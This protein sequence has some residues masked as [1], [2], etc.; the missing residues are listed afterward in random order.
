LLSGM[1][2]TILVDVDPRDPATFLGVTVILAVI[3]LLGLY[4]PARRASRV[5]PV[6]ALAAE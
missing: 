2:G 6:R 1:L 3:S 5:D 4:V